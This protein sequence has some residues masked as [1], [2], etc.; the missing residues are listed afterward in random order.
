MTKDRFSQQSDHYRLYRPGYPPELFA[1]LAAIAPGTQRAWDCGCGTGQASLPLAGYFDEVIASDLSWQQ[2][3]QAERANNLRFCAASADAPPFADNSVDLI[4]VA[5]ALH[6][7]DL[8]KFFAA[9]ERI[10]KPGGVLAVLTY[11]LLSISEEIDPLIHHLYFDVLGDYWDAERK[12]VENAYA[13]IDF[14]FTEQSFADSEMRSSW[15]CE[16][17]LGYLG[18]WSAVKQYASA[19]GG[20]AVRQIAPQ[21]KALWPDAGNATLPVRW[22]LR[23]IVR[24]KNGS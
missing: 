9:C 12:L 6:W 2:L 14:P 20:D 18:T 10:L 8:P 22:P 15:S 1:R 4:L 16:Q 3:S 21:V 17:L 23:C 11:N 24:R 7:F 13:D 19:T 5:Q